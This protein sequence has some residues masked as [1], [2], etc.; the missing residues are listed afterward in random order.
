MF[1]DNDCLYV[2][3]LTQP[4]LW[5]PVTCAPDAIGTEETHTFEEIFGIRAGVVVL[6]AEEY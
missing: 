5:F 6:L 4:I 1:L 3:E 2:D